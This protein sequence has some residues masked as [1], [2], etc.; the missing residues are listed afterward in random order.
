M[1]YTNGAIP[2]ADLVPVPGNP[3]LFLLPGA[4]AAW[5]RLATAVLAKHGW[6]PTLTDAYR[7]YDAQVTLFLSR[8]RVQLFGSGPFGDVRWWRG[9]RYVRF[10]GAAA[11]VPG[12]SNHGFG[13]TVDVWGLESFTSTRYAQ[14]MSV[15][16]ERG[17]S[18]SEGRVVKEPWHQRWFAAADIHVND[19][20]HVIPIVPDVA[21]IN[22]PTPITPTHVQEDD[23][24]SLILWCYRELVGR[25]PSVDEVASWI[26]TSTGH[27]PAQ[28]LDNFLA[29]EVEPCGVTK[30][31]RDYLA[32]DPN[33]DQVA[34]WDQPGMTIRAVR[35]GVKRS[36]E[37]LARKV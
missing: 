15:A 20:V 21:V 7:S 34:S 2:R 12:T 29:S 10:T 6:L 1:T 24:L 22:P 17:W 18:N 13:E 3:G 26:E 25:G 4:A 9:K 27:T 37:A 14:F 16:A 30:A 33:P 32:H 5:T 23:M 19:V 8:Y 11:A 36:P 35:D 31:F 28:V